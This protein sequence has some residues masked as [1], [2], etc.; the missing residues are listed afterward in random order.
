MPYDVFP[1]QSPSEKEL[2]RARAEIPE[3]RFRR[4]QALN[5]SERSKLNQAF[6]LKGLIWT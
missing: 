2:A 4:G 5:W 1:I 3:R 6:Q